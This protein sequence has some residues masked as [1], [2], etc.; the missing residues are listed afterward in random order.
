[1]DSNLHN[2][3]NESLLHDILTI[4]NEFINNK[5][6]YKNFYD[7]NQKEIIETLILMGFNIE[8]IDMC[9]CFF[10]INTIE[11]AVHFMSKENEI[12]Q[13]DY[14]LSEGN[15]C[16]IC[17]EYSDHKNFIIDKEKKLKKLKELNDSFNS[18]FRSSIEYLRESNANRRSIISNKSDLISFNEVKNTN[19]FEI[20]FNSNDKKINNANS[21]NNIN[22]EFKLK[23]EFE[24]LT[25]KENLIVSNNSN[26]EVFYEDDSFNDS[27]SIDQNVYIKPLN[28]E[29]RKLMKFDIRDKIKVLDIGETQ[30]KLVKY[31]EEDLFENANLLTGIFVYFIISSQ[32]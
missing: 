3:K 27:Y 18:K 17:N 29:R 5:I 20:G 15:L 8:M 13:H 7:N 32:R 22:N 1:M 11:K 24:N 23:N 10:T 14:I 9:F 6:L 28:G 25:N 21:G 19:I 30:D 26:K 4:K 2:L 31:V 16:I 12:W